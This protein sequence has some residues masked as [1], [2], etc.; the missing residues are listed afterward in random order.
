MTVP[1]KIS[2]LLRLLLTGLLIA[3]G[4]SLA[5]ASDATDAV[6]KGNE[7]IARRDVDA[8]IA[9]F[10]T[11]IQ[12][13]PKDPAALYYRGMAYDMKGDTA[14]S[15]VDFSASIALN[16]GSPVT[17]IVRGVAYAKIGDTAPAFDDAN[18]AIKLDPHNAAALCLRGGLYEQKDDHGRALADFT[19]SLQTDPDYYFSY[20]GRA[21]LYQNQGDYALANQDLEQVLR[22]SPNSE[23]ALNGLAWNLAT[24]PDPAFRNGA[25]A[26][27]YAMKVCELTKWKNAGYIDTLAAVYAEIGDF[28][29]AV[30]TQ[31]KAVALLG[32]GERGDEL[33]DHLKLFEQN[34]PFHE[35]A[36]TKAK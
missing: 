28:E 23:D 10:S 24:A 8:A 34:L 14:R 1:V 36:K 31:K 2:P 16:P 33:R 11:A 18:A 35:A 4:G 30:K 9:S 6:A 17:Y 20:L 25:R 21:S 3:A 19:A 5:R 12:L 26:L 13:N 32:A 27:R 7:A 22:L 29:E 15:I